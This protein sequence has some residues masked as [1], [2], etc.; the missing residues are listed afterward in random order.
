VSFV[1]N[2]T[3]RGE[4]VFWVCPLV[5][6]S[7]KLDLAAAEDRYRVL[8]K[9]FG[10][11]VVMTH[12]R[13]KAQE[14]EAAMQRFAKG[15]ATLLVS[16]TV[17]EV[18]VDVPAAT[19]MIIEH[20][21]RFGLAQL[22]QLRG[23]IGRGQLEGTCLLLYGKKI[24]FIARQR[25][26]M[27]KKTN[28]GFELAEADLRLRGGGE[29]LGLRQSGLPKFKFADFSA[30]EPEVYEALQNLYEIADQDA[31]DLLAKDPTLTSEQ[32]QA[33]WFLLKLFNLDEAERL[34]RAG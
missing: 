7:E 15:D 33:S 8:E 28:D 29:M 17:I 22:H 13:I 11:K 24:S 3:A 25:L 1:E 23:R 31:K 34:K 20:A 26:Q 12:G 16:T 21:E 19:V 14:K 9:L 18:G 6:E 2:V 30:E 32:G 10:D 5:E 27:M 4:K